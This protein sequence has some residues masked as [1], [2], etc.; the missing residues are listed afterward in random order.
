LNEGKDHCSSY[1]STG[2]DNR[3]LHGFLLINHQILYYEKGKS[4]Q[5]S[6]TEDAR[7]EAGKRILDE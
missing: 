6:H 5:N 2:A 1:I 4:G 7:L 3:N